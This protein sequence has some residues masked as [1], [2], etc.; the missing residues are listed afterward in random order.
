[1]ST[2]ARFLGCVWAAPVT[3]FGLIYASLFCSFGWYK[4]M[5]RFDNALVWRVEETKS[6]AWLLKAWLRWGGHTIG[7]VVVLRNDLLTDR[8]KVT[9]RHEQEHVRQCMILG[10]F[11]P[12]IYAL[13]W[14]GIKL[15][16]RNSD[17]YFSNPFEID[18][19]RAAGQLV[20]VE[21]ATAQLKAKAAKTTSTR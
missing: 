2:F 1:M 4:Y 5:G 14:I 19:R 18:A 10:V 21:G 6:P 3:V 13:A 17:P 8:S 20:D 16:C 9:L 15:A 11:Q 7:N 12:I